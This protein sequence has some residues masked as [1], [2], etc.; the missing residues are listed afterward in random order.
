M[1]KPINTL[2]SFWTFNALHVFVV[3]FWFVFI[4][5]LLLNL[6]NNWTYYCI[7]IQLMDDCVPLFAL[8]N[9]CWFEL[10]LLLLLTT[11][12]Y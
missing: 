5:S 7:T 4:L 8:E 11:I 2:T 12:K 3:S 9:S 10:I 6:Q 1:V